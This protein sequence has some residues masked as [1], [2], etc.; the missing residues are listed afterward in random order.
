[1][2]WINILLL[3]IALLFVS[4]GC[5]CD[6]WDCDDQC[7]YCH[8]YDGHSHDC[9]NYDPHDDCYYEDQYHNNNYNENCDHYNN[10]N[11]S[12]TIIIIDN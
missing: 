12:P 5:D 1:M 11:E 4:I 6:D 10:N 2:K 3:T 9:P 8:Y 7:E